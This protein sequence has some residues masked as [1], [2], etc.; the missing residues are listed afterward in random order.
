MKLIEID[1]DQKPFF[2]GDDLRFK[3]FKFYC[4]YCKRKLSISIESIREKSW[5]WK[6]DFNE[7]FLSELSK[8]FNVNFSDK[9]IGDG[10]KT[11]CFKVCK[12]CGTKNYVFFIVDEF[13][14]SRFRIF[15]RGLAT[16]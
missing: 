3:K 12:K 10:F 15:Y 6:K 9:F 7:S 14:N 13:A 16:D 1:L 2:M 8:V 5:T 4:P 11:I